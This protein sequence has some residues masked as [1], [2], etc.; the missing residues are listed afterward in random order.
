MLVEKNLVNIHIEFCCCVILIMKN[1]INAKCNEAV[2][3]IMYLCNTQ[4]IA[5][6][7]FKLPKFLA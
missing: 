2:G 3:A 7:G 1:W 6:P 5:Y 4:V